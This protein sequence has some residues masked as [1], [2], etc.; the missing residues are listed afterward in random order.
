[1]R[2]A[3]EAGY[4]F[5]QT[6]TLPFLPGLHLISHNFQNQIASDDLLETASNSVFGQKVALVVLDS[7]ACLGRPE[8]VSA[9]ERGGAR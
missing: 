6:L 9:V 7:F 3:T 4:R 1:M 5:T 8:G 2:L